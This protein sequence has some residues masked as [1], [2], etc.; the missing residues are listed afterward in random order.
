MTDNTKN[1]EIVLFDD[2]IDFL[3]VFEDFLSE[4]CPYAI[5]SFTDVS[6]GLDYL[7]FNKGRIVGVFSDYQMPSIDG[8]E[9]KKKMIENKIDIP[10]FICTGFWDKK[11]AV[12][13]M[14]LQIQAF[15]DKSLNRDEYDEAFEKFLKPRYE[16]LI[17]NRELIEGFLDETLSMLD[18]IEEL[19]LALEERP[20]ES[21]ETLKT[22]FRLLHTVKGT[23]SCVGL[24]HFA[25][26][27]HEYEDYITKVR[28]G[29][30]PLNMESINVLLKGLD[31]LKVLYSR[32][33]QDFLDPTDVLFDKNFFEV[34]EGES[35]ESASEN[36]PI[37]Q[38]IQES[39][40][41]V[42]K[43]EGNEKVS[44]SMSVLDQFLE[45][46]GELTILKNTLVK[47]SDKIFSKY[48]QDTDVIYLRDLLQGIHGVTNNI[49]SNIE[50]LRKI[51]F[52][53]VIRP[54]QR[55]VRDVSKSL[56]KEIEFKVEGD[57]FLIDSRV[58][59]SLGS[60]MVHLIRNS[61]DH[62]V[63]MPDQRQIKG[64][65]SKG[66]I[67]LVLEVK[68]NK[69]FITLSDDG[70]GLDP[71]ILKQKALEKNLYSQLELDSMSDSNALKLIFESGFST[72][73]QVSDLSG[74]GVGM[75]MVRNAIKSFDG[76]IEIT[77]TLGEG[78]NFHI[79]IPEPKNITI[80]NS[81]SVFTQG[82]NILSIPSDS[83]DEISYI[84]DGS[85][86][87]FSAGYKTFFKSQ[88][89]IYDLLDLSDYFYTTPLQGE[90]YYVVACSSK[91]RRLAIKVSTLGELEEI[92]LRPLNSFI[93]NRDYYSGVA[94]SSD[95]QMI[96]VLNLETLLD[97]LSISENIR[98]ISKDVSL[99]LSSELTQDFLLVNTH[100]YGA[101]ALYLEDVIR[102]E[103]VKISDIYFSSSTPLIKYFGRPCVLL[104]F[105]PS[106]HN[107]F[108]SIEL[109]I[110]KSENRNFAFV[111]KSVIG[112]IQSSEGQV[113]STVSTSHI[114]GLL[115]YQE[116]FYN[117]IN[118]KSV[119]K[120]SFDR[121]QTIKMPSEDL[122]KEYKESA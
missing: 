69:I 4:F 92:V 31:F 25:S 57:H 40:P 44:I 15:I 6:E 46:S 86:Q 60:A 9:L 28:D 113:Q 88:D 111:V 79:M 95:D 102:L 18:E 33:S 50:D 17:E 47:T 70:K 107:K 27:S 90:S 71:E 56:G 108:E 118:M 120:S 89:V 85:E 36:S 41:K 51:T 45:D 98:N 42:T 63:E 74:R 105:T 55:L 52:K 68:D 112:I 97:K 117:V 30:T 114:S 110:I 115:S 32:V 58:G 91:G 77:S 76:E 96:F 109:V 106:L 16:S 75:D 5:K 22:Y 82:G 54:Y 12:K 20:E 34:Q 59:K 43:S 101:S 100:D 122:K 87:I 104:N 53:D 24:D 80:I 37:E 14:E 99:E 26:F 49:Q 103:T 83:I 35:I 67:K 61:V 65:D 10:L 21:Q 8:F 119:L 81:L 116:K 29:K 39:I 19:I 73:E 38:N 48:K 11:M 94:L 1:Y 64:K 7:K 66:L 23:A 3:E 84:T 78:T 72:A 121:R 13:A 93:V 62:G 2:E